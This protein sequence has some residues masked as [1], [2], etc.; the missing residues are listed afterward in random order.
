MQ[1]QSIRTRYGEKRIEVRLPEGWNLLGNL[2]TGEL[3]PI[4]ADEIKK[5]LAHPIGRPPLEE[6]AL[7]KKNA[8]ISASDVTRS[9]QGDVVLPLLLDTLNHAGIPDGRILVIMGGGTHSPPPDLGS[10]S[11]RKYGKEVADRVRIL[12]HD[13]DRDLVRVGE[14]KRGHRVE[15]NRRVIES[16]LKIGFGGII[17]HAFGGYSGGAKSILPGVSSRESII[18]NHVMVT[19]PNVGMGLV[20]G[21][22]IREEMEEAADLAGLDFIFNLV[23]DAGGRPVGAVAG[24]FRRAYRTGVALARKIFQAELPGP[25]RVVITSGHP[26]DIHFY[27]SLNGPAC[28][29][30]A[31]TDGG[32]IIH[33]TPAHQGV[34]ENTRRLFSAVKKIGYKNLFERLQ[35]G[36][37]EDETLKS[38]FLP[39]VN[40]GLGMLIFRSMI[41][42]QIR[43]KVVTEEKLCGE[44]QEMGFGYAPTLEKAIA[45]VREE[46]PRADV[47]AASSAKVIVTL[48]TE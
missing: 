28:V 13:P 8:V 5:A 39:E 20:E 24:D 35:R 17:P 45:Q 29:L 41:D 37:R 47:A 4:G 42:R 43:I 30:N 33:L 19:D 11:L 31:C 12:Y 26:Y 9:V 48:G 46:F 27:Q 16:D 22:P 7:G 36:E 15:I 21:N 25:A 2:S 10:A 32:T 18:Q 34:L 38:F 6:I 40:I 23:L 3:P 44:L 1:N 14:T